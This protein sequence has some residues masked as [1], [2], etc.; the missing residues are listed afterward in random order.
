MASWRFLRK[1]SAGF[2][3]TGDEL[4]SWALASPPKL[5]L[6]ISHGILPEEILLTERGA[7]EKN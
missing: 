6:I 7:L 3:R 2:G 4:S 5:A 1:C